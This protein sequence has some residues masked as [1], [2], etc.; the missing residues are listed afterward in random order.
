MRR[1]LFLALGLSA[2]LWTVSAMPG[3]GNVASPDVAS[4]F[5][6]TN[7]A[8]GPSVH[9]SLDEGGSWTSAEADTDGPSQA[10]LKW[11]AQQHTIG[12]VTESIWKSALVHVELGATRAAHSGDTVLAFSSPDPPLSS[13]PHYLRHTPLLI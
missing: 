8:S 12:V 13:V 10:D 4:G 7:V 6:R 1:L 11:R 3:A 9:R 2:L 5:S